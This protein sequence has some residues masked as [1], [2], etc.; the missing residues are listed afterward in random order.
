MLA[1]PLALSAQNAL[2]MYQLSQ[3]N[4]RGT[5]RF[6]SMGG[7]FTALGGDLT[8]L[9]Q[10][11]GGIG[12]YTSSE[13]G[14]TLDI[15]FQR[16][17]TTDPGYPNN[18]NTQTKAACNNFG[19]VGAV[20]TGSDLMPFFNWGASYSRVSSFNRHYK[21]TLD[22]PTSVSNY[23]AAN[24]SLLSPGY[25]TSDLDGYTSGYNPYQDTYAP[26]MSI[27]AYN[28]YA[29]N[30]VDPLATSGTNYTGLFNGK[31]SGVASFD[32]LEQGY[33]DEYSIN[34]G[35]NFVNTVYWGVG[36]G[37]TDISYTQQAYY[38]EDMQNIAIP[39]NGTDPS[40]GGSA[41]IGTENGDGFIDL[42]SWKS[43]NGTGFNFK[44]GVIV[45]PIQQFR[46]GAAIHTPTYYNL[47]SQTYSSMGFSFPKTGYEGWTET[48]EG[49]VQYTDWTMRSPWRFMVGAAGIIGRYGL[50]SVD[51]E[52]K[53]YGDMRSGARGGNTFDVIN[54]D[55]QNYYRGV[56]TL[57]V[58]AEWR[59]SNNVSIRA[60]FAW[61]S[62]P[63][64]DG[65][66]EG[67][68][69]IYTEGAYGTETTPSYSFDGNTIYGTCGI[70]YHYGNFYIDAAYVHRHRNSTFHAFDT[71]DLNYLNQ[72]LP[73]SYAATPVSQV[74]DNNNNLVFTLGFRF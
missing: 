71:Y 12:V 15:D 11:P 21:G 63:V 19:Y 43:I 47:T 61:E 65:V 18:V 13:I 67:E 40:T 68:Q 32:I 35:G 72:S 7:A 36:F 26:W 57:R 28:A 34:F 54:G 17:S 52:Y 55:V 44:A 74:T 2:D 31:S 70:G 29:I 48:D 27:L 25:T 45:R 1:L 33:I 49:Y 37:I 46:I 73:A 60:G 5:A 51:Y 39:S 50:V 16:T 4:L 10:N 38:S 42:D 30:P 69:I 56:S 3:G 66:N 58:G 41:A 14:A 8:T 24:T 64:K 62:S 59:V 23:I 20:Q 6:M 9:N 53:A 22:M